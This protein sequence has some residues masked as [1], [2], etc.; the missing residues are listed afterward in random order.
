MSVQGVTF[1][2]TYIYHLRTAFYVKIPSM[3]FHH[4]DNLKDNGDTRAIPKCN[5]FKNA[6]VLKSKRTIQIL[7]TAS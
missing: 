3:L 6:C 2:N 1:K 5:I 4:F 7:L